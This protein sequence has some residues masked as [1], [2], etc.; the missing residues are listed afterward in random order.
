MSLLARARFPLPDADTDGPVPLGGFNIPGTGGAP[1]RGGLALSDF[2][3][4][5]GADRSLVT[6]LFSLAPFDISESK[7]P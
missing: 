5:M 3:S 2:F 7:A 4:I 6:V 1:P